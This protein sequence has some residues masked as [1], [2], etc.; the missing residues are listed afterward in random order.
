[1]GLFSGVRR[2]G[3]TPYLV[4][5]W[6]VTCTDDFAGCMNETKYVAQTHFALVRVSIIAEIQQV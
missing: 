6:C 1:M 4:M 2:E 3:N 5:H